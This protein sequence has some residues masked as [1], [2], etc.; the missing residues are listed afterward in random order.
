MRKTAQFQAA[1]GEPVTFTLEV[2]NAADRAPLTVTT[3]DIGQMFVKQGDGSLLGL[4]QVV[5]VIPAIEPIPPHECRTATYTIS[6]PF[7]CGVFRNQAVVLAQNGVLIGT[8]GTRVLVDGAACAQAQ[9]VGGLIITEMNLSPKRDWNDTRGGNGTPFDGT[10]GDGAVNPDDAW[11]EITGG[12][13][14]TESW[15]LQLTDG[16]GATFTKVL[17]PSVTTS[18]TR[19]L[20]Q[21]GLG[22]APVVRV[23]ILDQN[24]VV[25]QSLDIAAIE[26]ALGQATGPNDETLTWSIYGSPTPLFQQFVRRP[27]TINQFLPF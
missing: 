18:Q 5:P 6:L 8:S 2:C 21:W 24:G 25:R 19:L 23:A 10:P 20:T 11:I 27:A 26:Q 14:P 7:E 17:G 12:T 22:S 9:S 1:P 16:T 15:R 3:S 4:P 13:T